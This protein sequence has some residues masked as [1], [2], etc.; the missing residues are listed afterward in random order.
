MT[1]QAG[2]VDIIWLCV[3]LVCVWRIEVLT[4]RI[5]ELERWK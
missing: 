1:D 5:A 4:R 3:V 2:I